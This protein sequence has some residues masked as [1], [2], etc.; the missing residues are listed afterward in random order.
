MIPSIPISKFSDFIVDLS[1]GQ[2]CSPPG[3]LNGL[4]GLGLSFRQHGFWLPVSYAVLSQGCS[5]EIKICKFPLVKSKDL[6]NQ[7]NSCVKCSGSSE[8]FQNLSARFRSDTEKSAFLDFYQK[9][10]LEAEP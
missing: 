6:I 5:S 9:F 4:L 1:W 10:L 3:V 2:L 8:K 7:V